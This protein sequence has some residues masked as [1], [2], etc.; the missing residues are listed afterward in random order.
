MVRSVTTFDPEWTDEDI[1]AALAW[2]DDE[3][4]RCSGCGIHRDE[5][6][7]PGGDQLYDAEP[8]VCHA[9]AA[10]DRA[11]ADASNKK[12]DPAG[13]FWRVFRRPGR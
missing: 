13:V 11:R 1:D 5:S 12:L 6:M 4:L 10:K 2:A 8:I 7:A 3:A 9:C